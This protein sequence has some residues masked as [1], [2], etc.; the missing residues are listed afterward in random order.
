MVDKQKIGKGGFRLGAGRK[1]KS[2]LKGDTSQVMRIPNSDLSAVIELLEK[3]RAIRV[4]SNT[5]RA[6]NAKLNPIKK[7][8]PQLSYKIA[9]GIPNS[10]NDYIETSLDLNESLVKNSPA[11]FFLD[12]IGHSMINAGIFDGDKIIL[13]RSIKPKHGDIVVAIVNSE[14]TVKRLYKKNNKVELH[15]ENQEFSTITFKNYEELNIFGVVTNTIHKVL[16]V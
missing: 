11:T 6:H 5:T 2:G 15:A 7:Y 3:R 8:L 4:F 16:K 1:P 13:D 12:M 14:H 9:A 10:A